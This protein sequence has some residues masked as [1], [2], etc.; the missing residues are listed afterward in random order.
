MNLITCKKF[1]GGDSLKF[2]VKSCEFLSGGRVSSR[3]AGGSSS[4]WRLGSLFSF[5]FSVALLFGMSGAWAANVYW[6]GAEDTYWNN[7][8]NWSGADSSRP[9]PTND[10][11]YFERQYYDTRFTENEV[12]FD[13]AYVN[14]WKSYVRNVGTSAEP[15]IFRATA[16]A[17]GLQFSG[18]NRH[19]YIANNAASYLQLK[20]GTWS[21]LGNLEI[22][23]GAHGELTLTDGAKL[24]VGNYLHFKQGKLILE[25]ATVKIPSQQL[26]IGE[27]ADATLSLKNGGVLEVKKIVRKNNDNTVLFDGG[28]IKALNGTLM[29]DKD[30]IIVKVGALGGAINAN[31]LAVSFPCPII[32][33]ES[34]NDG[35]MTF[36]GG[37][38]V[39][40]QYENTY[41]GGTTIEG[42]TCVK[43]ATKTAA[44]KLLGNALNVTLP[45]LDFD[46]GEFPL[47]TITGEG[48]FS[49]KDLEKVKF[50]PS[51][52]K[53]DGYEFALSDDS[54]SLVLCSLLYR[55][56]TI[57][58]SEPKLVFP[59]KTLEDLAKY[60]LRARMQGPNFDADGAE[61]T[62]F[63]RRQETKD[64]NVLTKVT[65]Q[66]QALDE[67]SSRHYTKDA[68]V[69]FTADE[70]GVYAK[71]AEKHSNY[72]DQ[73]TFGTTRDPTGTIGYIPYDF[74]LVAPANAISVNINPTG[75]PGVEN[76]LNNESSVRYGG[77]DYAVP[78][79]EWS[80]F[81]LP[82][83]QESVSETIGGVTVTV[84]NQK[85][86][87]Y[88]SNVNSTW[89]L[90]YGYIDDSDAKPN[91]TITVTNIPYEFYRVVVYMSSDTANCR[92]GHLSM[93]GKN[94]TA[95]GD[96]RL[97]DAVTTVEGTD[98]WGYANAGTGNYLYGLKE[99]VNYLVSDINV[100]S[101]A[102]IVGHRSSSTVRTGIAAF[103]IVESTKPTFKTTV[104]D[105]GEK[106]FS[107]L[108]WD[109]EKS[110][111]FTD[112]DQ[113][114]VNIESD[115]TLVFENDVNVYAIKFNIAEGKKL[116]LTGAKVG[117]QYIAVTGGTSLIIDND[118]DAAK[119]AYTSENSQQLVINQGKTL[120]I[121]ELSGNI[122]ILNNGTLV[123]TGDGTVTLQLNNASEG[124][125]TVRS[126]TL[127]MSSKNGSGSEHTI[128]VK[129]GATL[130]LNGNSDNN[131]RVILEDGANLVNKRSHIGNDKAQTIKITLEG[132]ATVTAGY[133]FGLVAPGYGST[134]IELGSN[135][136]TLDGTAS[137]WIVNT[138]ITGEGTIVVEKGMLQVP[139]GASSSETCT[140]NIGANGM[141]RID[142]GLSLAVKN[143][144]NG[145]A[146]WYDSQYANLG[147]G[148][149]VVTGTLS[150][151]NRIRNLEL[152]SG[153]TV[154]AMGTAQVVSETFAVS[155]TGDKNI[156]IDASAITAAALRKVGETGVAVLT[157]PADYTYTG[158]NWNVDGA[159]VDR[160]RAKWRVNEDGTK[161][162][163]IARSEGFKVIVR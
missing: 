65:Y 97:S 144:H 141:L 80:N 136:L 13:G 4:S 89:D 16:E 150:A 74:R 149:L 31:G 8:N 116:T 35:G 93:N 30:G 55:G 39:T 95:S 11:M 121:K 71:L 99:G 103:Q 138:T 146:V 87:Y 48:E 34:V 118:V 102:T 50:A 100:G 26:C 66:L 68:T 115:T 86:N 120:T 134:S 10:D 44:E 61:A 23:S 51:V 129:S 69:E 46:I 119:I 58:Q 81:S 28:T 137:F 19:T 12:I 41:T 155:G 54:K 64:G 158:V 135:T 101:T 70:S 56:G 110:E 107:E 148:K 160:V 151:G 142:N 17:N 161:T 83:S 3:A 7:P 76:T 114:V 73:N 122:N 131:V 62:F 82:N 90:R 94:Y 130:D 132:D 140:L 133:N 2:R 139:K 78:Y 15:L 92:F 36:K 124:V 147:K 159:R 153:A 59:G 154:K 18:S 40:L 37:G 128:L 63:N 52:S 29:D 88:C 60:T 57:N 20:S 22:G 112:E 6:T 47:V 91:P 125:T 75:R 156:T 67:A 1:K 27:V 127:K 157:V 106:Q 9:V 21:A 33:A 85:G 105:G 111:Y 25:N 38:S 42:G 126:G 152:A 14:A 123:K 43:V 108:V 109:K 145:G 53:T 113:L 45:A 162:L 117:S 5:I 24:T 72:G 104:S 98:T 163:Y 84:N 96:A 49:E 143:F 32:A 79:S 77:G